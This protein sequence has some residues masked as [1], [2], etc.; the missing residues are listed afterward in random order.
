MI[1]LGEL[2]QGTSKL[3]IDK[4]P[5]EGKVYV[6]DEGNLHIRPLSPSRSLKVY[7]FA[8]AFSW[9]YYGEA[10]SQLAL[11]LLLEI[12]DN[13]SL[14]KD[15]SLEFTEVIAKIRD[16]CWAIHADFIREWII[17]QRTNKDTNRPED[18]QVSEALVR[19]MNR[20]PG[21]AKDSWKRS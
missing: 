16:T 2:M 3:T 5:G 12:S 15:L 17:S 6:I 1:F 20:V 11:A 4:S 10:P 9:G 8:D 7:R 13:E 18:S 14:C 19:S 21:G